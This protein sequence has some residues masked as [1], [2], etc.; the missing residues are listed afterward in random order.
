MTAPLDGLRV[1]ELT[2]SVTNA[3]LGQ[4]LADA[5]AEVIQIEPIGGTPLRGHAAY[6]MWGRGKKSI[7][8]DLKSSAD[9]DVAKRIIAGADVLLDSFRT[10]VT[11]RLGIG[12]QQSSSRNARLIYCSVTGW[13]TEGRYANAPG[14]EGLVAAKLG[15]YHQY[16]PMIER[17]GPAFVAT[18]YLTYSAAIVAFQGILVA[19]REREDSGQ[20]QQVRT[21]LA[22]AVCGMD[23]YNQLI[24]ELTN[25]FP[26]AFTPQ[27]SMDADYTP[28]TGLT[29]RLLIAVTKDGLWL[30]FSQVQERLMRAFVHACGLDWVYDDERLAAFPDF[31]DKERILEA[32]DMLLEAVRSKTLA[33]WQEIFEKDHNVFAEVF[34]SGTE[35]LNHPQLIFN[36]QIVEFQDPLVGLTRQPGPLIQMDKTPSIIPTASHV[37]DE[38]RESII[39]SLTNQT[40]TSSVS[41][42]DGLPFRGVTVLDFGSFYAA[43][44]GT[45]LL[46]DLGARVIKFEPFS[47]EPLRTMLPFPETGAAK[48]MA[49]KESVALD[50]SRPEGRDIVLEMAKKADLI[51]SSFRAGVAPRLGLDSDA[52]L[53]VNPNLMFLD[54]P[55]FGTGGPYGH[56]PAFAP[57]IAAGAGV[58]MRNFTQPLSPEISM[59]LTL[60]QVRRMSAKITM[61]ANSSSTQPD[62]IAALTV[63]AAMALAAYVQKK[64]AGGQHL[65]TTMLHSTGHA[66]GDAMLEYSGFSPSFTI[67]DDALGFGALYRLY[68]AKEGWVF[69]ACASQTDRNRLDQSLVSLGHSIQNLQDDSLEKQLAL[70]FKERSAQAWEDYFL[71]LDVGCVAC[72]THDMQWQLM[73]DF[74][75]ES[76]F[77]AEI[78]HPVFGPY[79]RVGPLLSFSRSSTQSLAGSTLGQHTDSVLQDFGYSELEIA[80]LRTANIIQ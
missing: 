12:F 30:Q 60:P 47:G 69:L 51:L 14:Y 9:L 34:R 41:H 68:E 70:I 4:M 72:A 10:G 62:G 63:G 46:T 64:G 27:S 66:L 37:V 25:R 39:A 36:E 3:Q 77:L 31:T 74:G 5:G 61:A 44:Y 17:P 13:G 57:T 54:A 73:G 75:K 1:V 55:G 45:A 22:L 58:G 42:D 16:G 53:A 29:L 32:Y 28:S 18:Q 48:V 40:T 7:S 19:L 2:N 15:I 38:D 35:L 43:P 49:G 24:Q 33:E 79:P 78:D 67:D 65:L 26:E 50:I 23:P 80:D 52:F 56:C 59:S 11:D 8:L 20:G 6:P 71:P 76:G 21:S